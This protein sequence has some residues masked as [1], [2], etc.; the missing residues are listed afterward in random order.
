MKCLPHA[1]QH[2]CET[3]CLSS[4]LYLH[5]HTSKLRPVVMGL[6]VGRNKIVDDL[7][8]ENFYIALMEI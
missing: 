7:I 8:G 2:D 3:T 4:L 6:T 5:H 1:T